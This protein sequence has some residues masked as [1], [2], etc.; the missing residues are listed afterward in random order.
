VPAAV[1]VGGHGPPL[2]RLGLAGQHAGHADRATFPGRDR[3]DRTWGRRRIGA[4]IMV[5]MNEQTIAERIKQLEGKIRKARLEA[6]QMAAKLL[7][8]ENALLSQPRSNSTD[9]GDIAVLRARYEG[10]VKQADETQAQID[11]LHADE[12][13]TKYHR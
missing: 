2:A 10:L 5:A 8:K 13:S 11:K 1:K 6:M 7:I 12:H 3:Y 4:G 9:K